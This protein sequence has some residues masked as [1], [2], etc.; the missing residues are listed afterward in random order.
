MHLPAS[1]AHSLQ[2]KKPH[3]LDSHAVA[4]CEKNRT[5][6]FGNTGAVT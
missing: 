3:G 4:Y 1:H 2:T 5:V 6:Y